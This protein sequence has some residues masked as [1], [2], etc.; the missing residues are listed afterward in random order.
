MRLL[1]FHL[2]NDYCLSNYIRKT[3]IYFNIEFIKFIDY[4]KNVVIF[5]ILAT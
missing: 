1:A 3:A 2:T 4:P 5:S